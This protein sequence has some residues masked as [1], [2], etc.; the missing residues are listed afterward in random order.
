MLCQEEHVM[1]NLCQIKHTDSPT[2]N[3]L[4]DLP[5]EFDSIQFYLYAVKLQQW[6]F[7]YKAP[8]GAL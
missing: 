6:L 1:Q 3:H 2:A 5:F 8:Q 7:T 4:R